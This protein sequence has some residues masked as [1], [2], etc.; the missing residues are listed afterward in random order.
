MLSHAV[1]LR[2]LVEKAREWGGLKEAGFASLTGLVLYLL[3]DSP[4]WFAVGVS[5]LLLIVLASARSLH[6]LLLRLEWA[7]FALEHP[8]AAQ[9]AKVEVREMRN[10]RRFWRGLN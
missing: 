4:V 8:E 7:R 6:V 5:A 3:L 1:D 2:V 9:R 10:D